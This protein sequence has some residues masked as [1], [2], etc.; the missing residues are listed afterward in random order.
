IAAALEYAGYDVK[1]VVGTEGHSGRHGAS[2][3]PEALRWVWREYPK[4]IVASKGGPGSRHYITDF[5]DP[6]S[7]WQPVGEMHGAASALAVAKDGAVYVADSTVHGV[8]PETKTPVFKASPGAMMFGPDGR[9]YAALRNRIVSFGPDGAEKT[10]AAN[11]NAADLGV[12]SKGRIYFTEPAARRISLI[13]T[14]GRKR[15]VFQA[16]PDDDIVS[17]SGLRLSPDEHLLDV[18]DKGSRWVWS[19]EIAP[20]NGLRYGMAFHHL[21]APD[22][23]SA[24][25]AGAMT[26]DN[27]G[28]LYVATK[29]GIQISDQPGRVVGIIRNPASGTPSSIVFGGPGLQTLYATVG[30]RV[31]ARRMR[32]T[33]VYPWQPVKLPRPQL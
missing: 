4:P 14:D 13:D 1:F 27:T 11:V 7:D 15:V 17:F 29:L 3:L 26:L 23:S 31:Y 18:S 20:D 5:L 12:T 25:G 32:R 10:V 21:E 33:G 6:E 22:D 30:G 2:I 9:L 24:T 28:H 19:F 8:D 16:S